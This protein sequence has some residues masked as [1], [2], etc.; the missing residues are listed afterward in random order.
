MFG[1]V[2]TGFGY[3]VCDCVNTLHLDVWKQFKS[4]CLIHCMGLMDTGFVIIAPSCVVQEN[5]R[6]IL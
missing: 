1:L 6:F 2:I 5:R 3:I 4:D